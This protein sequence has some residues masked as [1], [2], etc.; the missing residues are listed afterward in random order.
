LRS[1]TASECTL[2]EKLERISH[3]DAEH[4]S[5]SSEDED[6]DPDEVVISSRAMKDPKL[7]EENRLDPFG[8]KDLVTPE[9][10]L[11][12]STSIYRSAV[13]VSATLHYSE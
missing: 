13:L 1:A 11:L 12:K 6:L 5:L 9:R 7:L 2:T 3:S 8:F 10:Y 4:E